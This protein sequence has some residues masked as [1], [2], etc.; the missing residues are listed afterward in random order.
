VPLTAVVTSPLQR[1]TETVGLLLDGRDTAVDVHEDA[2][3]GECRYGDWTGQDIKV[4]AKD[5]LW[6][7]VQSHPSAARFPG[8]DAESL[9]DMSARAVAAVR[10]WNARLGD[11]ATY[12]VCSHGDV[13]KA[14]LADAMGLHL[15]EFQRLVV[16]PCSVSVVRYTPLR[17]FV[18]RVNDTGGS[19]A[20]L[21][22]SPKK[23]RGRR[24][25]SPADSDAVVGGG[26]GA[27]D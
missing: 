9:A 23:R 8:A 22:P 4:L 17:P 7:V 16:D 26:A 11:D 5:P 19:V 25:A 12:V 20:A 21:V 2:G 10:H 14:V 3:V 24:K 15:D 13:I 1:C 27:G 18:E 6:K